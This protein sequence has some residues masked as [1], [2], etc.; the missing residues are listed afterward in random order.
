MLCV[1]YNAL[2]LSFVALL[3]IGSS[4]VQGPPLYGYSKGTQ[5]FTGTIRVGGDSV[6][7]GIKGDGVTNYIVHIDGVSSS[8]G[9]RSCDA[10]YNFANPTPAGALPMQTRM[11]RLQIGNTN[12]Y[13]DFN[14]WAPIVTD[15]YPAYQESHSYDF[16]WRPSPGDEVSVSSPATKWTNPTDDELS[17]SYNISIY[18]AVQGT[19]KSSGSAKFEA[20]DC[21]E[22]Q[23]PPTS[24]FPAT[25][26]PTPFFINQMATYYE[27]LKGVAADGVTLVLLRAIADSPGKAT[28][29]F[30]MTTNAKS[31]GSGALYPLVGEPHKSAGEASLTVSTRMLENKQHVAFAIYRPP[32]AFGVGSDRKLQFTVKFKGEDGS[33]GPR[34]DLNLFL[35]RPPVVLVHG[36]YDNPKACY[37][38]IEEIDDADQSMEDWLKIFGFNNIFCLDWKEWNG[39]KDPSDFV[40]NE[41]RVW[42]GK[43]GIREAL[44][45]MRRQRI[46]CTQADLVC[47][48]Q[49]GA[50]ARVYARGYS[51]QRPPVRMP[52]DHPHFHNPTKCS[53]MGCWYHRVDNYATGD[54]HRLVTISTTHRGSAVCNLFVAFDLYQKEKGAT[55]QW[56]DATRSAILGI[57][58]KFVD[59]KISGITTGGFYAQVPGSEQLR[60]LGPTPVASHAIACSCSNE[61]MRTVR[62]DDFSVSFGL[63]RKLGNYFGKMFLV[64]SLTPNDAQIYAFHKI[65]EFAQDDPHLSAETKNKL[66]Q[67]AKRFETLLTEYSKGGNDEEK[68]AELIYLIRQIVFQDDANDCTVA[69]Q[70]SYG[71]L[72]APFITKAENTL[73]GWA[74]RSKT[75]QNKVLD[76]LCDGG[77]LL[78]PNGFPDSFYGGRTTASTFVVPPIASEMLPPPTG[79]KAGTGLTSGSTKGGS[80][81]S[82]TPAEDAKIRDEIIGAWNWEF[83]VSEGNT[84]VGKLTILTNGTMSWLT[85]KAGTWKVANRKV[86]FHW[87]D[88]GSED[89]LSLIEDGMILDGMSSLGTKVR[90]VRIDRAD[91]EPPPT[92]TGGNAKFAGEFQTDLGKL[93]ISFSGNSISGTFAGGNGNFRGSITGTNAA[94]IGNFAGTQGTGEIEFSP[95]GM[96]FKAFYIDPDGP[97]KIYFTGTRIRESWKTRWWTDFISRHERVGRQQLLSYFWSSRLPGRAN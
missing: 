27:P 57:F 30:A 39:S 14:F 73:H 71:G 48:S 86:I 4:N 91:D 21:R 18:T 77:R 70:S 8:P 40:T 37:Q 76:L 95:D 79:E 32:M 47:H 67:L 97:T 82:T 81:G 90:L 6:K 96:S 74:P 92:P 50:I 3:L 12:F 5:L 80:S 49:G 51:L 41:N 24:Q 42:D 62:P 2:M 87:N 65:A 35:T 36:T 38:E 26:E 10:L 16:L 69:V 61:E 55:G 22:F 60:A 75:V 33:D 66:P 25:K 54:I 68:N 72:E 1:G 56:I 94:L 88:D 89:T 63:T 17:G 53:E 58:Q 7:T 13:Q 31:F 43:A 15:T 28:F 84:G 20:V 46:A 11:V 44:V 78:D 59:T 34:E 93:T 23:E 52:V 85:G 64:R 45:A 29:S 9:G 19:G 83:A